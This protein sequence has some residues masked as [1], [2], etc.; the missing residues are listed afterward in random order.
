MPQLRFL[1]SS[2]ALSVL[3]LILIV[4]AQA[5]ENDD[6]QSEKIRQWLESQNQTLSPDVVIEGKQAFL[7]SC[8][9]CHDASRALEKRKNLN[10]WR[11]I[12]RKMARKR[13]A[14]IYPEDFESIAIY[15]AWTAGPTSNTGTDGH[16]TTE[17]QDSFAGGQLDFDATLSSLWRGSPNNNDDLENNGFFPQLWFGGQWHSNTSP[18][19]FRVQ[20]CLTCHQKGSDTNRLELVEGVVILD[21]N[22]AFGTGVPGSKASIQAGRFI[23]PFGAFA[24]QSHPAT[25]RTVTKP[26]MYNMGQAVNRDD[27][28][29]ALL[30]MPFSDEGVMLNLSFPLSE[31]VTATIEPYLINGLQG[32]TTGVNFFQSRGISD[33][34][35]EP[36]YG[37]RVTLGNRNIRLGGSYMAGRLNDDSGTGI[38]DRQLDVELIGADLTYRYQDI[39]RVQVEY[40]KR[41]AERF[42]F[43]PGKLLDNEKIDGFNVEGELR[44]SEKPRISLIG[45]YDRIGHNAHLPPS[46]SSITDPDFDV[47]RITWGFNFTLPGGSTLQINHEH[48]LMPDELND[49]DVIGIRWV[50]TFSS[51]H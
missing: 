41:S 38:L 20:A 3:I 23:V 32:D 29:P 16:A 19:S 5:A 31:D 51:V 50:G 15:L 37:G 36:A 33:N 34:N 11:S 1:I 25:F 21:L 43:L 12:V 13:N 24:Q 22:K 27:I 2:L 42:L 9:D 45:R 47:S 49:T 4:P 8:T 17:N 44:L 26:L 40:A 35:S 48:W 46:G 28:G 30:P 39:A 6:S 18:M 14:I 7:E 10:G